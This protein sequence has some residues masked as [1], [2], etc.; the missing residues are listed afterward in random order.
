VVAYSSG[1]HAQGV[2][3]AAA[4]ANMPAVIV[5]PSDA[6]QAKRERTAALAPKVVLYDRDTAGSR[7]DRRAS[8][9]ARRRAGA[10][11]DDP[12]CHRR[13]G[14]AAARSCEDLRSSV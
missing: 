13:A 3:H 8:R 10:A 4:L 9:T 14:H 12:V 1:N 2:A 6:P 5:M 11:F 7:R